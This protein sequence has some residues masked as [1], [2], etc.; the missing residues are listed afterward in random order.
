MAPAR[1][2]RVTLDT[3][4]QVFAIDWQDGHK[5]VFPLDGLRRTCPCATC[6]GGHDQMGQLPDPDIFLVPGLMRWDKVTVEAVGAYALRFT[7]DDGHEAGIYTWER[8]RLTCPCKACLSER[9]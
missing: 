8:L 7:W 3:E 4:Q 1:A 2:K 6:S 5:T 9:D